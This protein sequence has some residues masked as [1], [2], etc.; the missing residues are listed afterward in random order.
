MKPGS[1]HSQRAVY[2]KPRTRKGDP[3]NIRARLTRAAAKEGKEG[4]DPLPS[5]TRL[6]PAA[7]DQ[8]GNPKHD[9]EGAHRKVK[10][11]R[12]KGPSRP[13]SALNPRVGRREG[14]HLKQA[15]RSH[16]VQP[17]RAATAL[18]HRAQPSRAA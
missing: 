10:I 13:S 17:P 6:R 5:S 14:G 11:R 4:G 9:R 12:W 15:V 2:K 8:G 3:P 7:R 18:S 1:V 16:Y